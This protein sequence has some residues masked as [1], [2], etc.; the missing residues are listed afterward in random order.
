MKQPG[1]NGKSASF[2]SFSSS[3]VEYIEARVLEVSFLMK[4]QVGGRLQ[5]HC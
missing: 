1:F 4:I 3:F 5:R 2:F